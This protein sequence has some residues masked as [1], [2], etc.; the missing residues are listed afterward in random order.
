MKLDFFNKLRRSSQP[1]PPLQIQEEY[2]AALDT[3][4][5]SPLWDKDF[6]ELYKYLP[7]DLSEETINYAYKKHLE[8]KL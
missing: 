6:T 1:I 5:T 2:L 8:S 4:M 3:I 7:N